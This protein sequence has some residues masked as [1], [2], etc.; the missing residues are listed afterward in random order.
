MRSFDLRALSLGL[1]VGFD[2]DGPTGIDIRTDANKR[3]L[4]MGT[5][6][7]L[8]EDKNRPAANLAYI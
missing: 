2:A 3:K 5:L 1:L 7:S 6:T 8:Q 4:T